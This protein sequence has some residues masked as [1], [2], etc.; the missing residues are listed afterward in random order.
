MTDIA[1]IGT[2]DRLISERVAAEILNISPDTLLRI[3]RRG[4]GPRRRKISPRRV[5]YKLS[6]VEAFRDG[7]LQSQ[8]MPQR[9]LVR[10]RSRRP[11]ARQARTHHR[12]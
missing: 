5:G 8:T 3:N 9:E 1:S 7:E 11:Q 10:R 12:R 4:E 2:P 6:E